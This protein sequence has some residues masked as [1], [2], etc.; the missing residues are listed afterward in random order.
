MS[1]ARMG[2]REVCRALSLTA[3]AA[4][5]GSGC[6][7]RAPAAAPVKAAAPAKAGP[8]PPLRLFEFRSSFWLNLHHELFGLAWQ[9][10]GGARDGVVWAAEATLSLEEDAVWN[11]AV[12]Y[13]VGH[14]LG[15]E[16]PAGGRQSLPGEES[17]RS[18]DEAPPGLSSG[19]EASSDGEKVLSELAA[20]VLRAGPVFAAH[21]WA[22]RKRENRV[23]IAEMAPD[24]RALGE[25]VAADL[26]RA[27]DT[28]WPDEAVRVDV[29]AYAGPAGAYVTLEPLHVRIAASEP[30]SS[31]HSGLEVLFHEVSHGLVE[32]L[33]D[34][35]DEACARHHKQAPPDLWH[36]MVFFTTGEILARRL[37]GHEPQADRMA[38]YQDDWRALPAILA[39]HWRPFLR[40]EGAWEA[41][42]NA[43]VRAL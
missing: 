13:Y 30:R 11:E 18:I 1:G 34:A 43:V 35:L 42:V 25:L 37:P 12:D 7:G 27:Y 10:A 6:G 40:G 26:G 21:G 39:A 17:A 38:L 31:G 22:T 14:V 33:K 3:A 2:R 4:A 15:A 32:K 5:I 16:P 8:R 19:V 24:A 23:W 28:P 20:V 36:A 41:A 29:V 9:R